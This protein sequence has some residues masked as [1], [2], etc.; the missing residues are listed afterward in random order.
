MRRRSHRRERRAGRR[1]RRDHP[2]EA[3]CGGRGRR[4]DLLSRLLAARDEGGAAMTDQQVRDEVV[5]GACSRA[6]RRRPWGSASRCGSSRRPPTRRPA[7]R[8]GGGRP[9]TPRDDRGRRPAL[10]RRRPRSQ[11]RC[12]G[13]RRC[14]SSAARR[15]ATP[16]GRLADPQGRAGADHAVA[17]APRRAGSTPRAPSA[18]ALD[19]RL[20]G[21]AAAPRTWLFGGGL[22]TCAGLQ[23]ALMEGAVIRLGLPPQAGRARRRGRAS[24]APPHARPRAGARL[25]FEARAQ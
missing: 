3:R 12:A 8:R 1:R 2:E 21:R 4:P 6:T 25:R 20:G 23:F 13:A 15:R 17:H 22:R 16:R 5:V 24:S 19:G 18:P 7:S 9:R 10:T 11:Q 14:G